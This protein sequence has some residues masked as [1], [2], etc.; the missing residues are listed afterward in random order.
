[1]EF[2]SFMLGH[3]LLREGRIDEALPQLQ[4]VPAGDSYA[5]ARE[6]RPDARTTK[7]DEAAKRS[8]ASFLAIPDADAWYFGA[9]M[10]AWAGKEQP[11][12]RLLDAGAKHN[13]CTYPSLDRDTMFDSI[14]NA[15]AFREARQTAIA[16]RD[17]FAPYTKI[18]IP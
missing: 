8:E 11:A 12:L 3:V 4:P 7:C 6:C 5:L 14:R 13:F 9:S 16:C 2:G 15:P 10:L 17:K 1:M 18:R